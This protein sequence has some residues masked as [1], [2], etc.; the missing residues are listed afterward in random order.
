M[1]ST[2]KK[3]V[4]LKH[5]E[6]FDEGLMDLLEV[7][8]EKIDTLNLNYKIIK[9]SNAQ[10]IK[11][12]RYHELEL[13]DKEAVIF[14]LHTIMARKDDHINELDNIIKEIN[15]EFEKGSKKIEDLMI[16]NEDKNRRLIKQNK[17]IS[18]KDKE[19]ERLNAL[20]EIAKKKTKLDSSNSSKPSS[21]NG[22][23][24][25]CN[26]R[27]KSDKKVGGQ[28]GHKAHISRLKNN[29][30]TINDIHVVKAPTG[31]VAVLNEADVIKYYRTQEIDL[32]IK[33]DIIETRYYI[34]ADGVNLPEEIMNKYKINPL[35]YSNGSKATV[36]YFNSKGYV[37]MERL[38]VML[39]ELSNGTFDIK[40][41][42]IALWN[43][44]FYEKA[45]STLEEY[46]DK[47]LKSKVIHVDE[48]G[49]K[50]S[51]KLAWFHVINTESIALFQVTEKR[52]YSDNG[53]INL[54]KPYSHYLMHDH[55]QPY[56]TYL[57][58]CI[59]VECNAHILRGLK[60]GYELD[61]STVCKQIEQLFIDAKNRKAT[62]ISQ[63]IDSISDEEYDSIKNQLNNLISAERIDFFEKNPNIKVKYEPDYIKLLKRLSDFDA[64]HLLFMKDFNV[65]FDN[66]IA[67]RQMRPTKAKKKISGQSI[68]IKSANH[69]AAIHS[70]N[71]TCSLQKTNTLEV[72]K[73]IFDQK[74]PF[75]LYA[76]VNSNLFSLKWNLHTNPKRDLLNGFKMLLNLLKRGFTSLFRITWNKVCFMVDTIWS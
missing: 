14:N 20:L 71:Q 7:C 22:Y 40:A 73:G 39:R 60:Q 75:I 15:E 34:S 4:Y 53:P 37:A 51:G 10:M 6:Y 46:K 45:Q 49:W 27:E 57:H 16:V 55:F 17:I 38:S 32:I 56:Y 70:I 62:L 76:S 68:N 64:Q 41:S 13:K 48:T 9:K 67:E 50:I 42:T 54:L 3:E 59:H 12:A 5:K 66:N 69:F 18:E 29:P 58:N 63:G 11:K 43:S 25:V 19:I 31:A 28:K 52:G 47:I 24:V 1:A 23:K 8:S 65:P 33:A 36:L 21:T 44:E 72:I 2:L 35:T 74:M 61:G 26:S 30:T